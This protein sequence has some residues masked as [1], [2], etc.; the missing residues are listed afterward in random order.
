MTELR[1]RLV[2]TGYAA[3]WGAVKALPEPLAR[4]AFE[5]HA[6]KYRIGAST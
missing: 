3:G 5:E 6:R 1:E 2:D 4:A